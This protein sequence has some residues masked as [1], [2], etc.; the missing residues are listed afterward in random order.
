MWV[1]TMRWLKMLL[2]LT[3]NKYNE[4]GMTMTTQS[5]T[6]FPCRCWRCVEAEKREQLE[7]VKRAIAQF[8]PKKELDLCL[9]QITKKG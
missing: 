3:R 6:L 5:S 9:V 8:E 2:M 7:A 1:L 4:K